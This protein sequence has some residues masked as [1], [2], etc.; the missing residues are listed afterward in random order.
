MLE[1]QIQKRI[2]DYLKRLPD[3]WVVKVISCN[4]NGT[5]DILA[6]VRGRFVALEVK[7]DT[8]R[9]SAIQDFQLEQ[10]ASAGGISAVVRSLDEAVAV[11]KNI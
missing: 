7:T 2:L 9:T 4:K 3:C 6:C 10:I 8:G 1:S 5:P 11:L